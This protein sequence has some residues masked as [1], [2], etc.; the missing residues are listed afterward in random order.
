MRLAAAFRACAL[1][2]CLAGSGAVAQSSDPAEQ[3]RV[4]LAALEDAA[5]QLTE[6]KKARSRIQALTATIRAF[7]NGLSAMREGLRRAAIQERALST[8]L[9]AK[10]EDVARLLGALQTYGRQ[11]S[12]TVLLHPSG[13]LGTARAGMLLTEIGPALNARAN[14]LRAELE[15]VQTL[16]TL[17]QAAANQM[18]QGLSQIQEARAALNTAM[19]NRTDLPKRFIADDTSVAVLI[20]SAETLDG[21]ASGLS[22]TVSEET[23]PPL[24]GATQKGRVALPVQGLILRAAGEA[25]A[26]GVVRPGVLLATRPSALVTSPTAATI[27]YTG[28]L[29]DY[30]QVAILEP[31]ADVLFV[32]AGLAETYG[33]AGE[34]IPADTPIGIMPGTDPADLLSPSSEGTGTE[35]SE[36]LYIEVR[37]KNAPVDP[38]EWFTLRADK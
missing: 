23:A 7:E 25:D 34:V 11:D 20:A 22:Q 1:A 28:P 6:A 3:A 8:R 19:A 21:F 5:Q 18:A 31:N 37:E 2:A 4:A 33:S 27:R 35:R 12:P 10:E 14:G 9:A 17:Q 30:G 24:T 16:R 26:A 32:F 13:A 38:S 15:E 36:T 29:L